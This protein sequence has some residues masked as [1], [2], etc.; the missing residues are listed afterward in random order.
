MNVYLA[1]LNKVGSCT[2]EYLSQSKDREKSRTLEKTGRR[3]NRSLGRDVAP[4]PSIFHLFFVPGEAQ[5][6]VGSSL[7][8]LTHFP[9]IG[10]TP[11]SCVLT[12]SRLITDKTKKTKQKF[13]LVGLL[14]P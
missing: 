1:G 14:V 8:I 13:I 10:G 2:Q 11:V 4:P 6:D 9:Y 12:L 5:H 7:H 3:N